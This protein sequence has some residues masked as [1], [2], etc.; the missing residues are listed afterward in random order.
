MSAYMTAAEAASALGISV[1]TLFALGRAT[2]RIAHAIEQT[3]D[4]RLIRPRAR[5]VGAYEPPV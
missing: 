1:P 2:G 4:G 3:E 5:Y